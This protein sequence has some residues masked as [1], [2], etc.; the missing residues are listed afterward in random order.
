MGIV[1]GVQQ[2]SQAGVV[3]I[4]AAQMLSEGNVGDSIAVDGTCLTITDLAHDSF[5][6]DVSAE[7]LRRTH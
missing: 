4:A 3:T 6:A 2:G 1:K 7:T 5:T